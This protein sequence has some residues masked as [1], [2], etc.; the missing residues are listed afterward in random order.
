LQK[1]VINLVFPKKKYNIMM[2]DKWANPNTIQ[3]F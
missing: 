3:I 1:E 2:E